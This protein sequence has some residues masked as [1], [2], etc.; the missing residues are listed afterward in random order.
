MYLN[1]ATMEDDDVKPTTSTEDSSSDGVGVDDAD[2]PSGV[3]SPTIQSVTKRS[4][5]SYYTVA[6]AILSILAAANPSLFVSIG[7]IFTTFFTWYLSTLEAAPLLTKIVTCALLGIVGDYGAQWFEYKKLCEL[8]RQ[9]HII[10]TTSSSWK[11]DYQRGRGIMMEN[12][13]ISCPLQHYGYD[14]FERMLPIEGGSSEFY[15]SFAAFV[16]VFFDCVVLDGIFVATG[17]LFGGIFE[18]RNLMKYVLTNLR[19]TYFSA[20]RA[21]LITDLSFAPVEFLAFRFLPLPLRVLSV[22]AVDLVWNGVVSYAFHCEVE[23]V[24]LM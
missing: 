3:T 2:I 22:N 12:F 10:S 14:L 18:G 7:G 15:M 5:T 17:I 19:N 8:R 4:T 1:E 21:A 9:H 20:L 24:D 23:N 16:H 13:L 6:A 11:Y